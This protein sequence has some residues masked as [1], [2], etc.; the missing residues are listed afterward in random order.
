MIYTKKLKGKRRG[1]ITPSGKI[2]IDRRLG[3]AARRCTLTHEI[4]HLERG[5]APRGTRFAAREEQTVRELTARRLITL[6][7]LTEAL[8]WVAPD[9]PYALAEQLWVDM[10]TLRIRLRHITPAEVGQVN[11][12]LDRRRPWHQ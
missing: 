9:D 3:Q 10:P 6:P 8:M 2:L 7:A 11:G 1:A 5:L 12:E 4:I